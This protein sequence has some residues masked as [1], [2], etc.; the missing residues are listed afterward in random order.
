MSEFT[1]S[2]AWKVHVRINQTDIHVWPTVFSHKM[3]KIEYFD[4]PLDHYVQI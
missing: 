2:I 3:N 1:K 4:P